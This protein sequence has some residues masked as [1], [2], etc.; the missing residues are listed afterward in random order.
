[1]LAGPRTNLD[2]LHRLAERSARPTAKAFPPATSSAISPR[3]YRRAAPDEAAIG[4]GALGA[5][6]SGQSARRPSMRR[7][8]IGRAAQPLGHRRCASNY[9]ASA[10]AT[11]DLLGRWQAAQRAA[12]LGARPGRNPQARKGSRLRPFQP[13]TALLYGA[14]RQTHMRLPDRQTA[15]RRRRTRRRRAC[16]RRCRAV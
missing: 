9:T 6:G 2:F 13:M 15:R 1:M 4:A 16:G 7:A 14:M 8:V 10:I 5:A 11:Y 3:I 12:E